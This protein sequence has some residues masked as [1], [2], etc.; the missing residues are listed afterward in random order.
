MNTKT[1]LLK[2]MAGQAEWRLSKYEQHEDLRS[3]NASR[4][5]EHAV[6]FIVNLPDD[7]RLFELIDAAGVKNPDDWYHALRDA[8]SRHGYTVNRTASPGGMIARLIAAASE[9]I[10]ED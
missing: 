9:F 2:V 1:N 5:I 6:E 3:L 7:H 8:I 4:A 10:S